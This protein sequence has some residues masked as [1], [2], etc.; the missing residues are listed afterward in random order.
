MVV[1][2]M[3]AQ[4]VEQGPVNSRA[5]TRVTGIV[6]KWSAVGRKPIVISHKAHLSFAVKMVQMFP[7][8]GST[9]NGQ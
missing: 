7:S 3:T 5:E 1:Q 6:W 4:R 9:E 2:L 8:L